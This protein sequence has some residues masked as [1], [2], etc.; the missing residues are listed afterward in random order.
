MITRAERA[1]LPQWVSLT[2]G[3]IART[4]T[5][6]APADS[7]DGED[8]LLVPG[9]VDL[10]VNGIGTDDQAR[11]DL[12]GF[13]RVGLALRRSGVTA[14]CPT[15]TSS[16]LDSY[17]DFLRRVAAARTDAVSQGLP[18]VLGAHLEGP[19]L[20][21]SG[22]HPSGLLR[23]ADPT[24]LEGLLERHRG[25]V[26]MVTLA[27]ERDP[28]F[29]ATALLCAHGVRVALGHSQCSY[30]VARA[31]A[32]AGASV[33]THCFN[34]MSGLDHRFPG[35]AAAAL[36][37][38]R[39]TPTLIADGVHVDPV[40]VRLATAARSRIAVVSDAVAVNPPVVARNGAAYLPDDTLA[41]ATT[42]LDGA[43]RA[44][45]HAGIPF[46]RAVDCV[47]TVP[48]T[49][50]D[51]ADRGAL[52]VGARADLVALDPQDLSVRRLWIGGVEAPISR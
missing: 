45:V 2:Q 39:L 15:L 24:W 37:D 13:R 33:V 38:D 10:Q 43:L 35:L 48:A 49:V 29:R 6:S 20:A 34:A 31:A 17:D 16:P 32:D 12:D 22:A 41:G 23:D 40:L 14:W 9:F 51:E 11:A 19:F 46:A 52:R 28:E 27:P 25:V 3:R 26:H 42:L 36:D 18:A 4:G 8:A 1:G 21:T 5:G 47:A 44:L 50:A 30:E 7:I